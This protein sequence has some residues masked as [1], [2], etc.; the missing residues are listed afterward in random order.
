[1]PIDNNV[2]IDQQQIQIL[3]Q[4]IKAEVSRLHNVRLPPTLLVEP[5]RL[6]YVRN[7]SSSVS[8]LEQKEQ[9]TGAYTTTEI[10]FP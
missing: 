2:T 10:H 5:D 3:V 6:Q 8:L 1:M 4:L 9:W 7:N